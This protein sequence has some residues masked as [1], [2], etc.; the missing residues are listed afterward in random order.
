MLND[1]LTYETAVEFTNTIQGV[2]THLRYFNIDT[3]S[4]RALIY[5]VWLSKQVRTE[6]NVALPPYFKLKG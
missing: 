1:G 3:S 4:N 6:S 5:V 2:L